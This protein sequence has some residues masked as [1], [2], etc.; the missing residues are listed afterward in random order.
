M[1]C[2]L[3]GQCCRITLVSVDGVD[4]AGT[5]VVGHGCRRILG[6]DGDEEEGNQ[7]G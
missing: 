6:M 7:Y 2:W 3:G 4:V 1:K 5:K